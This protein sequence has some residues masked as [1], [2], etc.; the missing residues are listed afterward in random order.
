MPALAVDFNELLPAT[1]VVDQILLWVELA[2]Q[3][4]GVGDLKLSPQQHI[5]LVRGELTEQ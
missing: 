5:A 2:S 4:I 1:D 3:L